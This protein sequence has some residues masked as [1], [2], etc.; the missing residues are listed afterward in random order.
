[1]LKW[2]LMLSTLPWVI[3]IVGIRL[4]MENAL[5]LSG[6][7]EFNDIAAVI[8]AG[9]FLMG[10]MLAGTMSDYKESEKL[11][12]E[13]ATA[14]EG[15]ED[16]MTL[17]SNKPGLDLTT[18][19]GHLLR[20]GETLN[21]WLVHQRSIQDVYDNLT[22]LVSVCQELDRAGAGPYAA[23]AASEVHTLRKVSTRIDVISKTGFLASGYAILEVTVGAI[24]ILL[25]I[26][27]FKNMIAQYTIIS[28]LSLLYLYL[29][30]LIRDIDDPFDYA[31][32][33][34]RSGSAEVDLTPFQRY[35]ER[36]RAR[37]STAAS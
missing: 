31:P 25:L 6:F 5:D 37:I 14:L 1:M 4:F 24:I 12:A 27:H 2:R 19:R 36:L 18:L 15:I 28:F 13:L 23:K 10:F 20:M 34:K 26:S 32:D 30:R 35:V 9:A 3:L 22:A 7:V 16:A 17:A 21:Q 29:L 11:P 33:Q 8:T